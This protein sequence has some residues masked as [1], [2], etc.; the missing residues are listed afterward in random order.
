MV[1]RAER[2]SLEER[3]LSVI[4]RSHNQ[5]KSDDSKIQVRVDATCHEEF[6]R[7]LI[8]IPPRRNK[9]GIGLLRG[10]IQIPPCRNKKGIG[11]KKKKSYFNY[12][13]ARD[14]LSLPERAYH[15]QVYSA[16]VASADHIAINKSL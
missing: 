1:Q 7:G 2:Q 6:L 8:Q 13:A 10:L 9:K 15:F 14:K 5:T 16:A 12:K 3:R 11:C 4:T